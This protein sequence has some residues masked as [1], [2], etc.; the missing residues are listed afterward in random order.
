MPTP[1]D[2]P[3][4]PKT[5][6]LPQM[7][8][9]ALLE[10]LRGMV[11]EGFV[12]L[13]ANLELVATDV[14]IV[15][16][17]VGVLEQWRLDTEARQTKHSG[18]FQRLSETDAKHDAAIGTL[19]ADVAELKTSHAELAKASE[20]Q[21]KMLRAV[22]EEVVDGVKGFFSKHPQ[23]TASL[24]TLIVTAIGAATAWIAAKGH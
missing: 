8:D 15:K 9:R 7:T 22:K 12:E 17:R 1:P 21:T 10:E 5:V 24:V 23:V 13:R 3:P 18:G 14:T 19:V 16:Q 11:K 20:E 2:M 4:Q 6:E